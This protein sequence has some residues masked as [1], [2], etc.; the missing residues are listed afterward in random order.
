MKKVIN[1]RELINSLAESLHHCSDEKLAELADK[2]LDLKVQYEQSGHFTVSGANKSFLI[3]NLINAGTV[4]LFGND[5]ERLYVEFSQSL[6]D[7][8][9]SV[10][11][12][13]FRMY[14][15]KEGI[16]YRDIDIQSLKKEKI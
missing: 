9:E 6:S 13:K 5:I 1:R 2:A 16:G 3:G 10:A 4:D 12:A 8:S 15:S 7:V 11:I 14:L